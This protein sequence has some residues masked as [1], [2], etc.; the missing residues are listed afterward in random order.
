MSA[1]ID[2]LATRTTVDTSGAQVPAGAQ[3]GAQLA[4]AANTGLD[5]VTIEGKTDPYNILKHTIDQR[6]KIKVPPKYF[7]KHTWGSDA[8][9]LDE[10]N[11][12][13]GIIFP[14]TPTISYGVKADWS[15]IK[16][17]HSNFNIPFYQR[18]SVGEIS[19]TGRFTVENSIDAKIYLSTVHLLRAVTKMRFGGSGGD[20]D[21]GAPPPIC[22]LFAFG[23][24]YNVP[25]AITS[26]R[27]ELPND[28][29]YFSLN[30]KT[31]VPTIS[32]LSVTCLPVYSRKEMQNF[33]VTKYLNK[34]DGFAGYI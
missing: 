34:T 6:V 31:S 5:T 28:C 2:R 7:T 10:K 22:R 4:A 13:G 17:L 16:P 19:I 1:Y 21:S 25:V 30:G 29:D 33:S 14:Y 8:K 15:E 3:P 18:S 20:A 27:I 26:V 12:I 11:G 32:T 24:L 9:E 23:M